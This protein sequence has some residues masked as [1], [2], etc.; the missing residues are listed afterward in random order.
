M[1]EQVG[2][3]VNFLL[4]VMACQPACVMQKQQ[5]ANEGH[6]ERQPALPWSQACPAD[7][8]WQGRW[9]GTYLGSVLVIAGAGQSKN[10]F[11]Q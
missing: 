10:R 11:S 6:R 9:E 8:E 7:L 4:C 5:R 2:N 3:E 1:S